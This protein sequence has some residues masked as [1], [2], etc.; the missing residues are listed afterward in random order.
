MLVEAG[1]NEG[2]GGSKYLV[3]INFIAPAI[4]GIPAERRCQRDLLADHDAETFFSHTKHILGPQLDHE[5]AGLLQ[6]TGDAPGILV[7]LQTLGKSSGRKFHR[8]F[9]GCRNAE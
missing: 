3:R 5:F 2:D 4:P 7:E 1:S 8:P 9:S 6:G